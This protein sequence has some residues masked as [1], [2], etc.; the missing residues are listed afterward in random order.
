MSVTSK[1][2][3]AEVTL[4]RILDAPRAAVFKAWTDPKQLAQWWGPKDFTN[5]VCEFDARPG[6]KMLIHMRAPHGAVYPMTGIIREIDP[7]RR[8]VFSD[9][10]VDMDGNVQLEGFT[11]VTF[12]EQ[13]GKTKLTV[14]STAT[15]VMP[16]AV[17]MLKGMNEGWTQSLDRLADLVTA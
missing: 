12:E 6:G 17:E 16:V 7:P 14:H 13:G 4:V 3:D 5:P 8:L 1:R 15:A 2:P 11:T 10:A 9:A